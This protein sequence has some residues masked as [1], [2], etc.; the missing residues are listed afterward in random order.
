V[1]FKN[2]NSGNHTHHIHIYQPDNQAAKD[3]LLFRDYLR[4]NEAARKEYNDVKLR[5]SKKYYTEPLAYTDG[6]TDVVLGILEK[7]REYFNDKEANFYI[8]TE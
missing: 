5:L 4:L 2:D 8:E 6:K 3:E 7:A 1:R